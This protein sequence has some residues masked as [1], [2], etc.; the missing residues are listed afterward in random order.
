MKKIRIFEYVQLVESVAPPNCIEAVSGVYS[1]YGL[2]PVTPGVHCLNA[3]R[4]AVPRAPPVERDE[5]MRMVDAHGRAICRQS[6]FHFLH[7]DFCQSVF[8]GMARYCIV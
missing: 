4:S 8:P 7:E 3:E 2:Q 5:K 1:T 6:N